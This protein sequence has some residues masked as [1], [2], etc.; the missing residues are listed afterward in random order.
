METENQSTKEKGAKLEREF[1]KYMKDQLGYDECYLN[2]K[3]KGKIS[4][5]EYEV[6]IIGKILSEEGRK[7]HNESLIVMV[8]GAL[9]LFFGFLDIIQIDKSVMIIIGAITF[10]GG[11]I[12]N[13]SK[14]KLYEYTW[15]ECKYYKNKVGK[16]IVNT[17]KYKVNDN[18]SSND[19]KFEFK[20]AI[21]VSGSGFIGNALR[22]AK[23]LSIDCFEKVGEMEF[24]K[25]NL[26]EIL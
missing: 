14:K 23:E 5:N 9:I 13:D 21:L 10:I 1:A 3:V 6:D 20:N 4:T 8:I 11:I 12:F 15:V 7:R 22:F 19:K 2:Q 24:N 25:I 26:D 17:L 16:D 18:N